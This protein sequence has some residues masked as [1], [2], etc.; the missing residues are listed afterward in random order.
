[1]SN[2]L[3]MEQMA[4]ELN[5][6]RRVISAVLNNRASDLRISQATEKRVR[7]Y[8]DRAG[9]VRSKSALQLKNGSASDMIGILYCG[10]FI[11]LPYLT[12]ALGYLTR[13]I[14]SLCGFS[15]ITGVEPERVYE[16]LSE[17]IAKGVKK[18]IWI[19]FNN[20]NEELLNA[21]KLFPLF[22]RLEKV[23]IF[24]FDALYP[25]AEQIYLKNG[26]ELVGFNS[27]KSYCQ[28]AGIFTRVGHKLVALDDVMQQSCLPLPGNDKLISAF[29]NAG[30][31]IFGLYPE[32]PTRSPDT[33]AK[34]AENLAGLYWQKGVKAAFIRNDRLAAEVISRL[35]DH[36]INV[37]GDL[38]VI[39]Y[40]GTAYS[41]WLQVPLTTFEHPIEE[42]CRCTMELIKT[43]K[44]AENAQCRLFDNKLIL[45]KSHGPTQ[46]N[47]TGDVQ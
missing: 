15:E 8:L 35:C 24:K 13:E 11:D 3:N 29:E 19:H 30:M 10:K 44:S 22:R 6:S 43:G 37:P 2:F 21:E 31:K 1:M 18:L 39:G 38:A 47:K 12:N 41:Q 28:A 4:N 23:V 46:I 42:M 40:S 20:P 45:R 17:Y 34:I 16:G 9:Y 25:G 32:D 33:A 14:R 36:G 5:L 27:E 7:E 26:I